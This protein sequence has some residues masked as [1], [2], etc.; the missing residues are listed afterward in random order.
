M[1]KKI[2]LVTGFFDINRKDYG[3]FSRTSEEYLEYFSFWASMKNDLII[4]C[5]KENEEKILN[6]RKKYNL[7]NKTKIYIIDDLF[8]IEKE[9]YEGFCKIEKDS[10]FLNFRYFNSK[11]QPENNA[12]YNY[13]MILKYR[14]LELASQIVDEET[15]LSWIDFGF[16]HGGERFVNSDEFN[17]EW[18]YDFP[19]DKITIFYKKNPFEINNM[20][21]YQKM[22]VGVMGAP[23]IIPK[24]LVKFFWQEYKNIVNTLILMDAMDDDQMYMN[25]LC[26][27]KKLNFNL[28]K[29]DWF[30]PIKQYGMSHLTEKKI[31]V[32]RKKIRIS[33]RMKYYL[34]MLNFLKRQ[35]LLFKK[36]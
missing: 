1:N 25:I 22:G 31:E 33:E 28:L 14:F 35:Y 2:T 5:E 11:E 13:L 24:K 21:A 10:D 36:L 4:F 18:T 29:S 23:I 27:S 17:V 3:K 19:L 12:K 9:I 30:L 32:K 34:H 26:K 15:L 7:E 20:N 6:I 16:N 8:E